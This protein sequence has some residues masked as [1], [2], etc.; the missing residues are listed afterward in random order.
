MTPAIDAIVSVRTA[1]VP[2]SSSATATPKIRSQAANRQNFG[3]WGDLKK[4]A[5]KE[6]KVVLNDLVKKCFADP[7]KGKRVFKIK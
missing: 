2:Q 1:G 5:V 6:A 4:A 3:W 7:F